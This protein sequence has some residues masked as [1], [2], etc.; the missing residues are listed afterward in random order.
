MPSA[1]TTVLV[2]LWVAAALVLLTLA[3]WLFSRYAG[4]PRGA[5]PRMPCGYRG[6]ED[7]PW[8]AG[9][10]HYEGDLL[11]HRGPDAASSLSR[12]RWQRGGL[13]LG[14]AQSLR[15]DG[16]AQELPEGLSLAV[17][18]YYGDTSFHLAMTE[19]H[20]TALRSWLEA[21]PPGWNSNVA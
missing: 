12:H 16:D 7:V 13:E 19:E 4:T 10:L 11:V 5:G 17:P 1:S 3:W 14:Y 8:R 21:A 20:Y 18:G 6:H 15:G 2:L 9:S